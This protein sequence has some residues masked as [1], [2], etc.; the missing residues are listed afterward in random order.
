MFGHDIVKLKIK[1]LKLKEGNDSSLDLIKLGIPYIGYY[2]SPTFKDLI[3]VNKLTGFAFE[4]IEFRN[5]QNE[6]IKSY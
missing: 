3:H 2:V 6:N 5:K 1:T 4:E